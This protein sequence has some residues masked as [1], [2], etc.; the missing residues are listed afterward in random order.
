MADQIA[1]PTDQHQTSLSS[2]VNTL[3]TAPETFLTPTPALHASTLVVAKRLLDPVAK[4]F[5]NVF[6]EIYL[7]GMDVEQIWEQVRMVTDEVVDDVMEVEVE[8]EEDDV[9]EDGLEGLEDEDVSDVDDEEDEEE[10][11][12]EMEENEFEGFHSEDEEGVEGESFLDTEAEEDFEEEEEDEEMEG[13]ASI[14]R[15]VDEQMF[16]SDDEENDEEGDAADEEAGEEYTKDVFG[17]NDK[18]FS[19]DDFNRQ[20]EEMENRNMMDEDDEIDYF[21]DPDQQNVEGEE[22]QPE[23]IKYEDFFGPK[24]GA[25]KVAGGKRKRTAG[26]DGS[27]AEKQEEEE[28]NDDQIFNRMQKDLF[29]DEEEDERDAVG[30]PASAA[31]KRQAAIADEIRRYE[32]ENIGKK[33]WTMMGEAKAR[34]RPTNALLE[35][36]VEFDRAAKPVPVITEETTQTLEEIIK[37]RILDQNFDDIVRRHPDSIPEF[38]ASRLLPDIDNE[39]SSKSLAEQYEDDYQ[40]K[41]N[42]TK[43]DA[44]DEKLYKEHEEISKLFADIVHKLDALTS[45][46]YTPKPP[47]ESITVVTNAPTIALEEA[48][49]TSLAAK[50]QLAPQEVYSADRRAMRAEGLLVGPSGLPQARS[51]MSREEKATNRRR[52]KQRLRKKLRAENEKKAVDEKAGKKQSQKDM[53]GDV[54][55]TLKSAGVTVIGKGGEKRDL[56]GKLQQG[57]KQTAAAGA[58]GLKL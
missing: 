34:D 55:K 57:G 44:R 35:E 20:T 32:M 9:D 36:D 13:D 46:H 39:R 14:D 15:D 51:E 4:Q 52:D 53:D 31:A 49:P 6:N 23:E 16:E 22:D 29:A 7:Q 42:P 24:K 17:L 10:Y 56:Q 12:S 19:I 28:D 37:Q 45:Y 18:F 30:K 3:E 25:K 50:D 2:L 33:D 43:T 38:K 8:D 26:D 11:G 1:T 40:K 54:V 47:T 5:S 48:Q 58:A 27:E 21:A 41:M